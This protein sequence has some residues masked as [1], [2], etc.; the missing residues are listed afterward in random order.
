M[1]KDSDFHKESFLAGILAFAACFAQRRIKNDESEI[2]VLG[3]LGEDIASNYGAEDE[4]VAKH[5]AK[6][7]TEEI[8]NCSQEICHFIKACEAVEDIHQHDDRADIH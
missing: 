3:A 6:Y 8:K 5:V 4:D 2:H 7:L 1:R